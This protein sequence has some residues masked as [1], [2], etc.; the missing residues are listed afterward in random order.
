MT[1]KTFRNVSVYDLIETLGVRNQADSDDNLPNYSWEASKSFID[2]WVADEIDENEVD[3]EQVKDD[4]QEAVSIKVEENVSKS[5]FVK[6]LNAIEYAIS[7]ALD[8]ANVPYDITTN[9]KKGTLTIAVDRKAIMRAWA[10]ETRGQ[11]IVSW[12]HNLTVNHIE[13]ATMLV[14]ILRHRDEVY[15]G[16]MKSDYNSFFD[17]RSEPDPGSYDELS[18]IARK[19]YVQGSIA[20]NRVRK[21][22]K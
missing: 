18:K 22:K 3:P 10:E 15:G 12:D 11:G 13:D 19:A 1:M 2:E 7:Q 5:M 16:S 14:N 17:S 21:A 20:R 4:I 9:E 6:T 8:R